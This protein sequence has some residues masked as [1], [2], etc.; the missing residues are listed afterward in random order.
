MELIE[1]VD[2]AAWTYNT[3]IIVSGY[4]PLQLVMGKSVTYQGNE[5]TE[6]LFE[7]KGVR[8]IMERH[9]EVGKKFREMKFG[10]K[11]DKAV[12]IRM[13]GYEDMIIEKNDEVFYQTQN[14]NVWL[15]PAK[16]TDVDNNWV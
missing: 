9:F 7:D 6:S 8:Q 13:R 5:A 1:A 2:H 3:N 10:A 15:G 14:E 11:L 4:T 12:C 16:V